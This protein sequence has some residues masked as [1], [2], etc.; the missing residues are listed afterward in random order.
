FAA[1]DGIVNENLAEN[2]VNE[3]QYT[4]AKFFYGFQIMMENIHSE[5]YSLL[6]DTYIKDK[7]ERNK[8]F[9]AIEHFDAIKK[10]AEWAIKWIESDSFAERLVAFAAVEGIFFSG[11]FCSIF[12]LKKRGLMPGLT[13]S[14]ELIS[15]D[16]GLHCDFACHLHNNHLINK[17]PKERIKE[18]IVDALN[19]ERE[20]IIESLPVKLIGM[21]SDLMTKYLEF[22]TDRL[23]V[24]LGC[25]KVYNSENPFDFMEMISL[26]GKT[27]FFEKRV[28]DYQKAGVLSDSNDSKDTFSFDDDF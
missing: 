11:S 22:V 8:L 5:T 4:E 3:V 25:E 26:E 21:N 1:S 24:E 15:R 6:I 9:T 10:K 12:W 13:F 19:I 2:F 14:N 7:Q 17:V 16:E 23:L 18:I 20:F 27:N 28:G